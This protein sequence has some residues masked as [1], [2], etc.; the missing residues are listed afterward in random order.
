MNQLYEIHLHNSDSFY[1]I[2]NSRYKVL[3]VLGDYL[4]N[5][6]MS[7]SLADGTYTIHEM[8]MDEEK[9]LARGNKCLECET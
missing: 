9:V 3:E 5:N 8:D 2:A 4:Q 7:H 1:V 6:K